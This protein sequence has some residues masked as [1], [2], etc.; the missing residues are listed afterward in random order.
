MMWCFQC[1]QQWTFKLY[2]IY[3][4]SH[5]KHFC[6]LFRFTLSSFI[7]IQ[8]YL[9]C[10][11]K[12]KYSCI[13]WREKRK[14]KQLSWHGYLWTIFFSLSLSP[15]MYWVQLI[16]EEESERGRKYLA[17]SDKW[18]TRL[19][20]VERRRRNQFSRCTSSEK[21]KLR[22]ISKLSSV[23]LW[24]FVGGRVNLSVDELMRKKPVTPPS[25]NDERE[26]SERK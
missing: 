26:E 9:S 10:R 17:N 22:M 14:K 7:P 24:H 16:W 25:V 5:C 12:T 13:S 1:V 3:L 8:V 2:F 18:C 20:V 6:L 15:P 23:L 21:D 11:V 4:S 19:S